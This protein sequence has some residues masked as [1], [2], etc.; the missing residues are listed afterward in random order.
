MRLLIPLMIILNAVE[1]WAFPDTIRHGYTSC[2]TCHVSPSGGGLMTDYGRSLSKELI[3]SSGYKNE[4]QPLHGALSFFRKPKILE[5][6]VVGGDARY[7]HRK[8]DSKTSEAEEKFWMQAQVRAGIL[9]EKLRLIGTIGNIENPRVTDKVDWVIP[10][11]YLMYSPEPKTTIRAGRFSPIYGLRLP[12]HNLWVKTEAGLQPW[13]R[14]DTAEFIYEDEKSFIA[15]AGFQSSSGMPLPYQTTGYTFNF[16]QV[17]GETYRLG[18]SGTN[19]EGQGQR[20]RT[21]T[22]HGTLGFTREWYA[23]VEVLR[24]WTSGVTK[25]VGFLR[26]GLEVSK[27]IIPYIQAQ[28][29]VDRE[30]IGNGQMRYGAGILWYPRPHFEVQLQF[31]QQQSKPTNSQEAFMVLHYYL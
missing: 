19:S 13:L 30:Q 9:F 27:G 12:D 3:S 11:A 24:S 2:T 31:E 21:A 4:E 28:G 18:V 22:A 20:R 29:R 10:E 15:L 25:D 17:V 1:T 16:Y 7:L 26:S 23:H 5:R 8:V 6:L 14:Q